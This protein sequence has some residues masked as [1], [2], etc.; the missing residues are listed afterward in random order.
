[1]TRPTI[2][3]SLQNRVLCLDGATGTRLGRENLT[4]ADFGGPR[5]EGCYE[6]LLLHRPELI[7]TV[8][9]EYLEAGADII[10]TNSFGGTP[11]VLAEYGL[12]ERARELNRLAAQLARLE[13]EAQSTPEKP[14]YVAGSMGPTTKTLLLTGG[15]T[16]DQLADHYRIQALGLIEGG[17]DYLL[18]ETATDPLNAK[19][20]FRGIDAACVELGTTL[21]VALSITVETSGTCLAGLPAE[22]FYTALETRD[23]LY[24]GLN[25]AVGPEFMAD[26]LRSLA[27]IATV[28]VA[29]VPNAGLPDENGR[30]LET[31][32]K[33]AATLE[34]FLAQ[35]W[36]NLIGGCCGTTA[37]HIRAFAEAARRH[38][39]RRPVAQRR[40]RVAGI[41]FL[42]LEEERRPL[43]V[44]ERTNVIGS[45]KF[46]DLV[47]AGEWD[48][49][50]EIGRGQVAGGAHIL[51]VCLA[52]PDRDERADMERLLQ[53][54]VKKVR[55]PVMIDSTDPKVIER[56]LQLIPGKPL[57]NSINLEDGEE[58]FS[59]VVPLARRYGA[60][61]IVGCIDEDPVQ[62]MAVTAER[63]L[64][65]ARRAF[66]LLTDKF[67]VNPADLI[68]D[69][70][71][72]PCASGDVHYR[73]SAR[74]TIE[75]VRRIKAE[76]PGAKTL[77]G[78]SNVSFGLPPAAREVLNSVFLH[79]CTEAGLDLAIV[80]SEKIVR[81]ASIQAEEREA[82]LDLLYDR[83][84][85][86][87]GRF[88]ALFRGEQRPSA[89]EPIQRQPIEVKLVQRVVEARREG[90]EEDLEEAL[91]RYAPLNLIN[92]P[93]LDGMNEVGRLFGKNELIVAE[94]LQSAEVMKAAVSYLE[95][96]MERG[97][98]GGKGTVLLATVKGDVHDI[99]KNLIGILLANNGFKLIDLGIKVDPGTL[100]Q[101]I[102]EHQPDI[103][104]LSG[105]LVK[106]AQQMAATAAD[107]RELGIGVPILVGGA[108]LS[109]K[110]TETRI[111]PAYEGIVLYARDAMEGLSLA[112]RLADKSGRNELAARTAQ[113]RAAALAAAS[114]GVEAVAASIAAAEEPAGPSVPPAEDVPKAPDYDP[115]IVDIPADVALA[116]INPQMLFGRHLGFKGNAQQ[117]AE[118]GEPKFLELRDLVN[119][120]VEKY[121]A[122]P[123]LRPRAIYRFFAAE[124]EGNDLILREQRGGREIGRFH[125]PRQSDRDRL[126]C[127]DWVE[128]AGG[129]P[130]AV[131]LFVTTAG[132]GVREEAARLKDAGEFLRSHALAATA[133]EMAEGAAEWLHA[134]LRALWGFPDPEGFTLQQQFR[135]EYRGIRVS[136]GYPACPALE[137]Q[138]LLF[139]LLQ[140]EPIGV[141]LT[142]GLMMDP[143]AS[144]S[145][146]VFHHPKARYF[147]AG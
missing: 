1:M 118:A 36:L 15:V 90:L 125:F 147:S 98:E 126:C 66:G 65:V 40:G 108:A 137:D 94:V 144:I 77:L 130:D 33:M 128:P 143:E 6:A 117:A 129:R 127:A 68:F 50:A 31:P 107:L 48:R 78:V 139:K 79:E 20:A 60:A 141:Q 9:R 52:D 95:R 12:A 121:A 134:K 19:A 145:A 45:K 93:L 46:R 114:G 119:G 140:P 104:G 24:V 13:A 71:V 135:N 111:L 38:Q 106:S 86:P 34:R 112:N 62:G 92:G 11:L 3:E 43:L 116:W 41:E 42:S 39:P 21:P 109:R 22:A 70:L 17:A 122:H 14:R 120:L 23:L 32:Q 30:Y 27:E 123:I 58:R 57:I 53:A 69:P 103:V 73:G 96:Y 54:L 105:L 85:D 59:R 142:E 89:G 75:G 29:C 74:E 87:A 25:C 146:V 35:G 101:A 115:H 55:L 91:S 47:K 84:Q 37:E 110:F 132:H 131:A 64:A 4:A 124:R 76:I 56:A 113:Q 102:G 67:G 8:H 28:P 63:K 2:F 26:P 18:V 83:G 138:R 16:F 100:A 49:A 97:P 72:F 82:A 44:G 99:G 80:N 61:L 5:F 81:F 10:E 133:L 136:F 88:T 7:R 51:D